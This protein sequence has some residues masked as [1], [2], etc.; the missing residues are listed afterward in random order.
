M[1]EKIKQWEKLTDTIT[2]DWIIEYFDLYDDEEISV[3]WVANDVGSIFEF[4]DMYFNFSD[5]LDCYKYNI[6]KEQLFNWYDFC[7]ENQFVNISLARFILSPQK[8]KQ[9]EEK[10]LSE[11]R[12]RVVEAEE[13]LNKAMEEYKL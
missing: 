4:A 7:L 11:L 5:I 10:Y 3:D 9:Q 2:K 13:T 1:K 6:S 8:R 12:Q